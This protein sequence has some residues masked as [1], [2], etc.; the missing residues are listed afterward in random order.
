MEKNIL[1]VTDSKFFREAIKLIISDVMDSVD[2]ASSVEELLDKLQNKTYKLVLCDLN[3]AQ[4]KLE[5]H[6]ETFK[7]LKSGTKFVVFSFDPPDKN[8]WLV[9]ELGAD[10]Y[11]N[12]PLNPEFVTEAVKSLLG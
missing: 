8:R 11:I 9:R 4:N 12:R 3:C 6:V 1:V 5:T 7:K 10:G 2:T